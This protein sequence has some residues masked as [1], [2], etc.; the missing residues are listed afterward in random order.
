LRRP[1]SS[2]SPS[3]PPVRGPS[4]P[5]SRGGGGGGGGGGARTVLSVGVSERDERLGR[6]GD[7]TREHEAVPGSRHRRGARV[8]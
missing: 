2:R 3:P 6:G 5:P 4:P 7:V 8:R 1:A